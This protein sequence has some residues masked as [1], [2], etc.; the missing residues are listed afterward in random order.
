MFLKSKEERLVRCLVK[1]LKVRTRQ[2]NIINT[3]PVH[4]SNLRSVSF[5]RGTDNGGSKKNFWHFHITIYFRAER[6]TWVFAEKCCKKQKA[7][8]TLFK[9]LTLETFVKGQIRHKRFVSYCI[10]VKILMPLISK[11]NQDFFSSLPIAIR[12]RVGSWTSKRR[13]A[14]VR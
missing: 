14:D 6:F 5:S 9:F 11:I 8:T 12:T 13:W 2:N 3:G 1:L 10:K 4:L 7:Q